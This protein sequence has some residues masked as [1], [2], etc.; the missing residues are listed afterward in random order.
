M[1]LVALTTH[2]EFTFPICIL[3]AHKDMVTKQMNFSIAFSDKRILLSFVFLFFLLLNILVHIE[4]L[5][6]ETTANQK[7]KKPKIR[8]QFREQNAGI[9]DV[10][11]TALNCIFRT[12]SILF[13]I[14]S[15]T[16]VTLVWLCPY[17]LSACFSLCLF[18]QFLV[19]VSFAIASLSSSAS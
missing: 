6:M 11:S 14:V 8:N 16:I 1:A 4:E 2:I 18:I 12:N 3:A 17:T 10:V 5:A 7:I 13:L 15:M 9:S 19:C